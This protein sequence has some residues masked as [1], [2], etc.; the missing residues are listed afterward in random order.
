M[1]T[2]HVKFL[3]RKQRFARK[4]VPDSIGSNLHASLSPKFRFLSSCRLAALA[5]RLRGFCKAN[6]L[7]T[8]ARRQRVVGLL[9][10]ISVGQRTPPTPSSQRQVI[11]LKR[12]CEQRSTPQHESMKR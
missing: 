6:A 3:L 5:R 11:E 2:E 1:E 7:R 4:L 12:P 9:S 10:T 8:I